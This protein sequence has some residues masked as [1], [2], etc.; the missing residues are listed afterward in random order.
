MD[1]T[2][3]GKANTLTNQHSI[4]IEGSIIDLSEPRVMGVLN[5][6][7][8]SFY[9]SSRM[10]GERAL[11][12]ASEKMLSEGATFLDI[13]GYS[14]RPGA[15]D[16]DDRE[17]MI[18]ITWA[19]ELI[20]EH[21]PDAL[22]SLDTFRSEVARVGLESGAKMINDISGGDLDPKMLGVVSD[23]GCPYVLMHMR[24]T[25]QNMT[26]KAN[27]QDLMLE[28]LG[29][30]SEKVKRAQMA[31][32]KDLILDPG[33]GFAKTIEQNFDLL[34][35]LELLSVFE[36]PLLV[37]VSRKSMIYKSLSISPNDALNGTTVLNTVA[38]LKGA[39]VLRCHDVKE[40]VEAIKLI[41]KVGGSC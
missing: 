24:G 19:I 11:L 12:S 41:E 9:A 29:S 5:I 36:L 27:Y 35:N 30:L 32:V 4:R 18:R 38:L 31:G 40:A 2:N 23:Y 20:L 13:G 26:E 6:T 1:I 3:V 10:N 7:P 17:E 21:F 25:P 37:G 28:I 22:I 15:T 16:I 33:F 8:D 39:S 14:S 34:S